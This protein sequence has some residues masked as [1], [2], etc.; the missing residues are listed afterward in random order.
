M[1]ECDVRNYSKRRIEEKE[2]LIKLVRNKY[3]KKMKDLWDE[4][5]VTG[6]G[7][8]ALFTHSWYFKK[9]T[10]SYNYGAVVGSQRDPE[11]VGDLLGLHKK[12]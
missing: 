5:F 10:K 4:Y 3:A 12:D 8:F 9:G 1:D 7:F 2:C 11:A 6:T